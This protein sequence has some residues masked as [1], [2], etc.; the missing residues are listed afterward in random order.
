VFIPQ[1]IQI[2]LFQIAERGPEH[3]AAWASPSLR[4]PTDCGFSIFAEGGVSPADSLLDLSCRRNDDSSAR[5]ALGIPAN[6]RSELIPR[7]SFSY[8]DGG[9]LVRDAATGQSEFQ[10]SSNQELRSFPQVLL[11]NRTA[12]EIENCLR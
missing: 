9:G 4:H 1:S 8:L 12:E 10:F 11:P 5:M 3:R 6:A 2:G 7:G